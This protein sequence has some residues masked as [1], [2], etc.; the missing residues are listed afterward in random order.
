MTTWQQFTASAPEL[1]AFGVRRLN[2][3]VAYLS[4]IR[5]DG[6]P[7][8]H[9]VTPHISQGILFV[10][11]EPTSPK[12]HDLERDG[13]FALHCS[14]EDS[15]GGEGEFSL[16]GHAKII[17]DPNL[18]DELFAAAT[19]DGFNPLER[20]VFFEF[21]IESVLTTVYE[22]DEPVRKRWKAS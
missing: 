15:S 11:M 12:L 1:A 19:A 2:G 7:R 10:Y 14:V 20:Y 4:T 18:R 16:H 6:G 3:K 21:G 22:N 13:R 8:V 9:P 17:E 5:A